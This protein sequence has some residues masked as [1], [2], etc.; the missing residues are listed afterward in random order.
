MTSHE[1]GTLMN[2]IENHCHIMLPLNR[3][4]RKNSP[5]LAL[6]LGVFAATAGCS[7]KTSSA[8]P[9][10][11]PAAE[12]QTSPAPSQP[13]S[14]QPAPP[15]G[16]PLVQADGQPDLSE[17]NR[18]LIRW[19]VGN[20]RPPKNFEDFAATAGFTIPPPPP[21]KKYVIAKNMHIELVSQ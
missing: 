10:S 15:P 14:P 19:I 21:G 20:R 16:S 11:P 8:T 5:L 1:Q 13:P 7:K 12:A 2:R 18:R 6:V 9:V 3:V 4:W 17:L